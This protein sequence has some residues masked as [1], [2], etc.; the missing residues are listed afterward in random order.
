MCHVKVW[1]RLSPSK[2]HKTLTHCPVLEHLLWSR[3]KVADAPNGA[4]KWTRAWHDSR[5]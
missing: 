5:Q 4:C 1:A 3:V 2:W